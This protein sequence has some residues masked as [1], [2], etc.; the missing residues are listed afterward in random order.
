MLAAPLVL[1]CRRVGGAA[2][3]WQCSDRFTASFELPIV[4][5]SQPLQELHPNWRDQRGSSR[6]R[7]LRAAVGLSIARLLQQNLPEP[8]N[9]FDPMHSGSP[10]AKADQTVQAAIDNQLNWSV[11]VQ[12]DARTS[13]NFRIRERLLVALKCSFVLPTS[14]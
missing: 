8:V 13:H 9:C 2:E 7:M 11:G 4:K 1:L 6:V 14:I 12:A 3:R 10:V 5:L